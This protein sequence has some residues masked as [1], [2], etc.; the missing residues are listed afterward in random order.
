LSDMWPRPAKAA[1]SSTATKMPG[2]LFT[3]RVT[4]SMRQWA[5]ERSRECSN[6]TTATK[7]PGRLLTHRV[8]Y[9][10][11]QWACERPRECSNVTTA[12]KMPGRF[13]L[14]ALNQHAVGSMRKVRRELQHYR[15]YKNAR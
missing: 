6:V 8:T 2:R 15:R 11:R 13:L 12:T 7:M 3:D 9:S 10:M 14:A 1:T 4:Y 5:C